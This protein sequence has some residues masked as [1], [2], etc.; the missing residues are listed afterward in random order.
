MT[1][2]P[3]DRARLAGMR[4]LGV[5]WKPGHAIPTYTACMSEQQKRK[6]D[7]LYDAMGEEF[8]SHHGNLGRYNSK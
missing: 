2:W 3:E 1:T 4:R 7:A 6:A 5:V 8:I